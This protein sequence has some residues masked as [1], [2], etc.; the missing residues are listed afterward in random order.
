MTGSTVECEFI[1]HPI[2]GEA[3]LRSVAL[4]HEACTGSKPLSPPQ[5]MRV[6][7]RALPVP[8]NRSTEHVSTPR[9]PEGRPKALLGY[10]GQ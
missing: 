1:V 8:S 7:A 5:T 6:R 4:L 3:A 9:T 10:L 2:M